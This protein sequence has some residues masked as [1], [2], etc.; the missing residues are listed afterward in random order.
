MPVQK[1]ERLVEQTGV[2]VMD[3]PFFSLMPFP[4]EQCHS[5][6]H[7]SY[8]PHASWSDPSVR[9]VKPTRTNSTFML[10]DASRYMPCLSKARH[11]RSLFDLKA[12]LERNDKDDGRPILFEQCEEE[13]RIVS[14]LGSKID[15]IYEIRDLL[16][17]GAWVQ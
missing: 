2:T 4:A 8:T 11:L 16:R 12:V 13:P 17:G 7:V 3:G 6:S 14:I 10:R 15:N 9:T 5:L 1:P